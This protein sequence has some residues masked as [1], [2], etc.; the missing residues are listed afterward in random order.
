MKLQSIDDLRA[1]PRNPRKISAE[2]LAGLKTSL[3]SYGDISGIVWNER[4][5]ELVAGHQRVRA[6]KAL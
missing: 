3:A 5:G 4:T 2:A 6:L 1:S